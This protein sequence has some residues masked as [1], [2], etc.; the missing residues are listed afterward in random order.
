MNKIYFVGAGPGAVD[1]ITLR[2]KR[3]LEKADCVIYAGSLVNPRLLDDTHEDCVHHNS[4]KL[5]LDEIVALM[6]EAYRAEKRV[7]RLHT[8]DPALYGAIREQMDR[9]E[10][11]GIPYEVCPGVSSF[12]ATAASLKAELTLPDVSQTVILTRMQGR[13]SVPEKEA[14]QQL[15]AHQASMAIFLSAGLLE[16]VQAALLAGGYAEDCPVALVYKASW[17]EERQC[18]GTLGSLVKMGREAGITKTAMII[19]GWCLGEDYGLSKLY[20]P[21]FETGYRGGQDAP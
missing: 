18:L 3:L 2:G 15:A 6:E 19:V 16:E 21:S 4:A 12:S 7:L 9:L 5:C 17:P 13:T 20:D 1:L 10:A 14:L 11:L 8:G